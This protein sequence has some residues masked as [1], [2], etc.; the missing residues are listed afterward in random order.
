VSLFVSGN[1]ASALAAQDA[2]I[3][4][5]TKP[6]DHVLILQCVDVAKQIIEGQKPQLLPHG[7][8][9]FRTTLD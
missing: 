4:Y 6:Y 2:A 3:G 8:T 9:L 7:L 5:I 1:Q